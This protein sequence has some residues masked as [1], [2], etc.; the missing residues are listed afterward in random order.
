M[1]ECFAHRYPCVPCACLVPEEARRW[2]WIPR[3]EWVLE[4]EPRS[5]AKAASALSCW[6]P[7]PDPKYVCMNYTSSSVSVWMRRTLSGDSNHFLDYKTLGDK[8]SDLYFSLQ[9]HA[10]F[11]GHIC[12]VFRKSSWDLSSNSIRHLRNP[13]YWIP[14]LSGAIYTGSHSLISLKAHSTRWNPYPTLLG[15]PRTWD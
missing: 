15:W 6:P 1:Y 12:I 13:S 2:C 5:S 7:C 11:R 9:M 8:V 10:I 14:S 4:I 3:T